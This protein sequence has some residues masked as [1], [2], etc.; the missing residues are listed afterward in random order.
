MLSVCS[1]VQ[2][3][4]RVKDRVLGILRLCFMVA[5]LL[6]V[7]VKVI[8]IDQGYNAHDT[9]IGTATTTL[10][11]VRAQQGFCARHHL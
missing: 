9:P 3:V 6:Y 1:P 4:V 8:F 11:P 10:L 7:F 5:I 2:Q